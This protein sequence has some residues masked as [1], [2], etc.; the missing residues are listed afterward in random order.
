[1]VTE[2]FKV[3]SGKNELRSISSLVPSGVSV[4]YPQE[5]GV[6]VYPSLENTRLLVFAS[7]RDAVSFLDWFAGKHNLCLIL[8]GFADV[9]VSSPRFLLSDY[10]MGEIYD[11]FGLEEGEDMV[12]RALKHF[13]S[14]EFW[15]H[16]SSDN[17]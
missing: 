15:R 14:L 13:W 5:L 6:R 8:R 3:V 7:L 4:F 2:V 12:V 16:R 10:W 9:D 17:Y 1:M 11:I